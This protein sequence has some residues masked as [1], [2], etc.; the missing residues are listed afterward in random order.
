MNYVFKFSFVLVFIIITYILYCVFDIGEVL[1]ETIISNNK[2]IQYLTIRYF[3]DG[4]Y[5]T[6]S[7]ARA[8]IQNLS[9]KE[10]RYGYGDEVDDLKRETQ[11]Q[12]RLN[13]I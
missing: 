3:S 6:E 12:Y 4:Q 1:N 7:L 8:L 2:S 10:I 11:K 5:N 9:L 13:G